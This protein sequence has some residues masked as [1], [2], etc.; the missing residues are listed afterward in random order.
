MIF[1]P[2]RSVLL[3]AGLMALLVA[4]VLNA[5]DEF[6]EI[7]PLSEVEPGMQGEWRTVIS[8]TRIE[9][10]PLKVVGV[11]VNF[12]GPRRSLILCE[13]LDEHS[14]VTGPVSG[15]SG[16]PVFIDGKLVG[17]YAYGFTWAKEQALIGVTPIE[18]MLE[19]WDWAEREE[20]D[21]IARRAGD[22][23]G[24]RRAWSEPPDRE[25][26]ESGAWRSFDDGA[27]PSRDLVRE[28]I[29]PLPTP[30]FVAGI[31]PSVMAA[32]EREF[33]QRGIQL[34]T[35]PMGRAR[36]D[37][38]LELKPGSAVAGMLMTGDFTFAGTGTV[39]HR[40]GDRILAFGHSFFGEGDVD[41]PM[42]PA[43]VMTVVQ[44][45][46]SSFKLSN[47][48]PVIGAI[49]QDRLSAIAG[50]LGRTAPVTEMEVRVRGRLG[51]DE[52]YRGEIFEDEFFSPLI[53]AMALMEALLDSRSAGGE[54][55]LLVETRFEIEGEEPL[56][57][58]D[59]AAGSSAPL[60][61]AYDHLFLYDQIVA[62]PFV[63]PRVKRV[64]VE[65]SSLD[66]QLL[67]QLDGVQLNRTRFPAGGEVEMLL[68]LRNHRGEA[69]TKRVRV[70][71]PESTGNG[72][73]T[74]F[75][76]DARAARGV[77]EARAATP[78]NFA[79][80]IDRLRDHYSH[81]EILIKVLEDAPG[82]AVEGQFLP[83]VP[84]SVGALYGSAGTTLPT[85]G[86][87][88]KTLWETRIRVDGEFRGNYRNS[89]SLEPAIQ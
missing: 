9:S 80:L 14:L 88:T 20:R 36:G 81:Q 7:M 38:D 10:F 35:A 50:T 32:F 44:S 60:V 8:G 34:E 71:L 1:Y 73:F 24:L 72:R 55:T 65:V 5:A 57:L 70:P 49:H 86:T 59:A 28:S 21:P 29:R 22:R 6:P 11:G 83:D 75:V 30:L 17:A 48:G 84:P 26:L 76:G 43:E 52:Y 4:P 68:R 51:E 16:S 63:F 62:N 67:T 3:S 42:A 82:L 66:E 25:M 15:M 27:L 45:V 64:E 53:S 77:S 12:L 54:K 23:G 31:S 69:T 79:Q 89:F 41:I 85:R 47:P 39:T 37:I 13:A 87:A 19:V 46:Q 33:R 58:R 78:R 56:V 18:D 40:M 2:R 74:L 61:L